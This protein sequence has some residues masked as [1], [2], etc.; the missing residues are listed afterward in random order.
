MTTQTKSPVKLLTIKE[1][2]SQNPV[3]EASLRRMIERKQIAH[4][5]P[6]G[7]GSKI[8]IPIDAFD[9]LLENQRQESASAS[10]ISGRTPNWKK[11]RPRRK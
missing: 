2:A 8:F 11:Q 3:S 5:Q 10:V 1:F 4:I 9:R 7:P 6:G